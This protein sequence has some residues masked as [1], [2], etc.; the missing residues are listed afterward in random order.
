[1]TQLYLT[2]AGLTAVNQAQSGGPAVNIERFTLGGDYRYTPP[3][4]SLYPGG[5]VTSQSNLRGAL[6]YPR[7][8][9]RAVPSNYHLAQDGITGVFS[10]VL[11]LEVGDFSYGEIA[12]YLPNNVMFAIGVL[13]YLQ[14]KLTSTPS[15]TGNMI[16]I[17]A[18]IQLNGVR[19]VINILNPNVAQANLTTVATTD[20]LA[21]PGV[22]PT[23]N[24]LTLL[25]DEY[26]RPNFMVQRDADRW[27][28]LHYDWRIY[29]GT[30]QSAGI[31]NLVDPG[32]ASSQVAVRD[33]RFLI[34]FLTG[35]LKG[36]VRQI[37]V[38]AAWASG[39]VYKVGDLVMN[40]A[41]TRVFR[42]TVAGTSGATEPTWNTAPASNTVDNTVTWNA[43]PGV[44]DT[45]SLAWKGS[46]ATAAA[47][48]DT[49]AVFRA[50]SGTGIYDYVNEHRVYARV[51][52]YFDNHN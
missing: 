8:T 49:Y 33:G 31:Y 37:T 22:S 44:N 32:L 10:L 26:D 43:T 45:T 50:F 15:Q 7:G 38:I 9:Q 16:Q 21:P 52:T 17:S 2:E 20:V 6:V 35:S 25:P 12:L 47:A 1:M 11:G 28:S 5:V 51:P 4:S 30:V 41:R 39:K 13:D 29:T 42:C 19:P 27:S 40:S 46:T 14:S 18:T 24:V 36:Q 48:G 34:Q 23:N 3:A